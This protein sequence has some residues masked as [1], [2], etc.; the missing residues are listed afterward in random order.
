MRKDLNMRKGKMM[1]QAAHA[2]MA[3]LTK[4]A[5]LNDD[6]CTLTAGFFPYDYHLLKEWL[7]DG[8][9]KV[10]LQVENLDELMTIYTKALDKGMMVSLIT[11]SGLTEFNGLPT[12]TCC[13]IGPV[14]NEDVDLLTGHLKLW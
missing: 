2:C 10:A 14:E 1:A 7:Q 12:I 4:T 9:T 8:F 13:S 5:T 6:T 3:L 11:D